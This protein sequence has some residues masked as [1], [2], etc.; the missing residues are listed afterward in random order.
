VDPETTVGVC[1]KVATTECFGPF[2]VDL[3]TIWG[4][5]AEGI[6][7]AVCQEWLKL[8]Y[9]EKVLQLINILFAWPMKII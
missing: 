4:C 8:M 5:G 6:V 7:V 9:Y 1:L 3:C 2:A